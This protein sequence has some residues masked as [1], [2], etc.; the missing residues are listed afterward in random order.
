MTIHQSFSKTS[1]A[2]GSDASRSV[3]AALAAAH[4]DWEARKVALLD[5]E[6]GLPSETHV[7][8][9]RSDSGAH[10][11]VVGVDYT[12][13]QQAELAPWVQPVLDAGHARI[14]SAGHVGGGRQVF[15]QAQ[16]T[17]ASVDV[18]GDQVFR[19]IFFG[20]SHNGSSSTSAGY[21]S[22]VVVCQNTMAAAARSVAFK[23]RHTSGVHAAVAAAAL[24]FQAQRALLQDQGA[25][26]R[27]LL[28]KKLS[29][30]NLVRYVREVL[31]EGAGNDATIPVRG[32]DRV[33]ALAHEGAGAAARAGTLWGGLNAV[34]NWASHERGRSE[35]ARQTALLFGQGG[36]LLERALDVAVAYAEKLPSN[37]AGRQASQ[38]HATAKAELDVLLGRPHVSVGPS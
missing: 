22:I 21:T 6:T 32:V 13:V 34:T 10:L 4:L 17:D 18:G 20:N 9:K 15:L 24:E 38:N 29:D 31:H 7:V 1:F 14:V 16:L 30:T 28:T 35:D 5:S 23:A 3:Q 11:G 8:V 12:P 19:S 2:P 36:Q 37:E 26:F 33:V 27:H 25:L